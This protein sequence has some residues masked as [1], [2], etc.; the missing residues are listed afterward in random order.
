MLLILCLFWMMQLIRV[1][2]WFFVLVGLV[3]FIPGLILSLGA[4]YVFGLGLGTL[5]VFCGAG[6]GQTLA[7]LLGRFLL[8]D[9]FQT[10]ARKLKFWQA[11]EI[12]LE[13][14]GWKIVGLLRLAPIVP[15][16]VLNY[17]LGATTVKVIAVNFELLLGL[18]TYPSSVCK[19]ASA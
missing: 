10:I 11:I 19:L 4:G 3:L 12:A 13:E 14:E 18:L 6:V 5:A 17:A 1:A 8:Q 9:Y 7:F 16:N 15:Y 2:D